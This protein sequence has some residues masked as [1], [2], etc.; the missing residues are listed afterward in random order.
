MDFSA[1]IVELSWFCAD[2]APYTPSL[3]QT[4]MSNHTESEL[5]RESD[6]PKMAPA[7][8]Q[9]TAPQPPNRVVVKQRTLQD[10]IIALVIGGSVL[11]FILFSILS[12]RAQ[13]VG[14]GRPGTIVEKLFLPQPET[15]YTWGKEPL[16]V[17]EIA[18]RYILRVKLHSTGEMYNVYVDDRTY[19]KF[20]VGQNYMVLV[21]ENGGKDVFQEAAEELGKTGKK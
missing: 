12:F 8:S 9:G 19:A 16:S 5:E 4:S 21:P 7:A 20:E 1:S 10:W 17:K 15:Q 13:V 3:P 2:T 6:A 18:G 14:L 11:G